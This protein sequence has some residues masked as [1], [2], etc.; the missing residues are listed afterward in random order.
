MKLASFENYKK[1]NFSLLG[2]VSRAR[3]V[4]HARETIHTLDDSNASRTIHVLGISVRVKFCSFLQKVNKFYSVQRGERESSLFRH[5]SVYRTSS[6]CPVCSVSICLSGL[7]V[8]SVCLSLTEIISHLFTR[9]IR[10]TQSHSHLES[11]SYLVK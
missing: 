3:N 4:F 1:V 9:L 5:M 6:V 2:H 10:F 11:H 8:L 7:T